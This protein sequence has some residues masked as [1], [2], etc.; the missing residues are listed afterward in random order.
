MIE[1]FI[2]DQRL[3]ERAPQV[4]R[5]LIEL[6]GGS[7]DWWLLWTEE[8]GFVLSVCEPPNEDQVVASHSRKA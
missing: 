8:Y 2:C 7:Q 1:R 4:Y 6:L 3:F 5:D